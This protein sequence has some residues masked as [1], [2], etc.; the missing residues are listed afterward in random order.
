M[1]KLNKCEKKLASRWCTFLNKCQVCKNSWC[2]FSISDERIFMLK[3]SIWI[4]VKRNWWVG[5]VTFHNVFSLTHTSMIYNFSW[6]KKVSNLK[7][8]YIVCLVFFLFFLPL[9]LDIWTKI[10]TFSTTF[11]THFW[12]YHY[13]TTFTTF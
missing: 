5:G 3:C 7:K 6:K 11:T 12:N 9:Y 1:F 4:N 2:K 10:I 8:I 13:F